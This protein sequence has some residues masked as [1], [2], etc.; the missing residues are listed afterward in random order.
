MP[1][2]GWQETLS[3]AQ[4]AGASLASFTTA[5]S[6]LPTPA[7]YTIGS[8]DWALGKM[9]RIT[10]A[11]YVGNVVTAQ[12]TF[13]VDV[14][15]GTIATPIVVFNMG[16]MLCSTTAHTTVPWFLDLIMTCRSL[17]SGTAATMIGQGVLTSR[18]FLDTG[19]TAD[20]VTGGHPTLI[21]PETTPAVGTGFDSNTPQTVDLFVA[22]S[23]S[24][25]SNTWRCEQYALQQLN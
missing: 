7:R 10:A 9:L 3:T 20:L 16:A 4:V 18:A 5:V 22:C 21:V 19:A 23:V 17:G 24:N 25:A 11:G 1:H 15:F 12:P 6:M 13:T 14:R 8:D 2:Q